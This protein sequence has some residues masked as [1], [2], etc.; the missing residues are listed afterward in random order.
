[1]DFKCVS[2]AQ[3]FTRKDSLMNHRR[4]THGKSKTKCRY[5]TP[6]LI[7]KKGEQECA[8]DHTPDQENVS[9]FKCS[10]CSECFAT[11]SQVL[12]HRKN[13]HPNK[14]P[15]CNSIK[16]KEICQYS[17]C[18]YNHDPTNKENIV[19]TTNTQKKAYQNV[20]Q[21]TK[22]ADEYTSTVSADTEVDFPALGFQ[23]DV[24]ATRPPDQITQIYGMMQLLMKEMQLLKNNSLNTKTN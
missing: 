4:D 2:C 11:K 23:Q 14:V 10:V 21:K 13:I 17:P 3:Q 24:T 8:F 9:Q 6:P 7:C 15:M 1:M 18:R 5:N 20:S 19:N 22:I 16:N 12:N